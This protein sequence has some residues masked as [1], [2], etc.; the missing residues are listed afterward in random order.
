LR[1]GNAGAEALRA[2]VLEGDNLVLAVEVGSLLNHREER[3]FGVAEIADSLLRV[4]GFE[5]RTQ[6]GRVEIS[7]ARPRAVIALGT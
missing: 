5:N 1:V 3:I 6:C 4:L 7:H 2:A